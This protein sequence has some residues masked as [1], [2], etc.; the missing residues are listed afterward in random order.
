M[1]VVRSYLEVKLVM[2]FVFL[3][4]VFSG[5]KIDVELTCFHGLAHWHDIARFG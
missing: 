4:V 5:G 3:H 2:F 1:T